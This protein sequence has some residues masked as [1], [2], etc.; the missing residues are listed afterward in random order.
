MAL[1]ARCLVAGG[2]RPEKSEKSEGHQATNEAPGYRMNDEITGLKE[3]F[4]VKH[5]SG[6]HPDR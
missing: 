5:N 3:P 4:D 2:H 6:H 1:T